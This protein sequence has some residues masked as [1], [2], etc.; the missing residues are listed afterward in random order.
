MKAVYF[1]I[2]TQSII[3]KIITLT[4]QDETNTAVVFIISVALFENKE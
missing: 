1:S 2:I 4:A 3:S